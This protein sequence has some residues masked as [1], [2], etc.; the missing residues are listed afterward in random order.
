MNYSH[1]SIEE[2]G[3]IHNCYK[4]NIGMFFHP[5]KENVRFRAER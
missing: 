4:R 5:D 1:L 2:R 3:C